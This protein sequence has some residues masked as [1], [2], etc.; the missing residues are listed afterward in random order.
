MGWLFLSS[1][2]IFIVCLEFISG[3][4]G[5][6]KLLDNLSSAGNDVTIDDGNNNG[7]Q[8]VKKNTFK[9]GPKVEPSKDSIDDNK[10]AGDNT[11]DAYF[12]KNSEFLIYA[13]ANNNMNE[14]KKAIRA[15][16]KVDARDPKGGNT[17]LL[18]ASYNGHIDIVSEL[19]NRGANIEIKST[20]GAKTPLL[21]AV[22]KN[23]I[24]II[25]LLIEKG[26]K[27]DAKNHRGDSALHIAAY[28]GYDSLVNLLLEH[29]AILDRINDQTYTTKHTA[30]HF[31][32]FKGHLDIAR[33]LIQ[34]GGAFM[35]LLDHK[36]NNC[37]QL[38]T[39]QQH[40]EVMNM[41]ID[42]HSD[43]IRID[44]QD[45]EGNSALHIAV[46]RTCF[47]CI[48]IL[49]LKGQINMELINKK[50]ETSLIT[51]IRV[52]NV[53]MVKALMLYG[54]DT[55]VTTRSHMTCNDYARS[56]GYLDIMQMMMLGSQQAVDEDM[57]SV[58]KDEL[59]LG[60]VQEVIVET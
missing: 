1:F 5:S 59:S 49:I 11:F 17:A 38:A 50:G 34:S 16:G 8:S 36:G 14:L 3:S 12:D 4:S 56:L 23:N 51:A 31:A 55:T 2:I 32:S 13:A 21:M 43:V 26:A 29:D 48:H 7:R 9:N 22:Y 60:D 6:I 40:F 27:V 35:N 15:G 57:V 19:L 28:M 33:T 25:K 18:F 47:E 54:V 42:E 53:E 30:L 46:E 44:H 20:D 45:H 24:D 37:L 39:V 41:F 10:R 58:L 52:G